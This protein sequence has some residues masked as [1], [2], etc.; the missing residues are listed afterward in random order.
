MGDNYLE[1]W[2]KSGNLCRPVGEQRSRRHEQAGLP[3]L[4]GLVLQ[5]QQQ[6]QHLDGL[7]KPHVVC[8]ARPKF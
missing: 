8:E 2:R 6:R 7:A 3:L 4:P 1:A 5:H